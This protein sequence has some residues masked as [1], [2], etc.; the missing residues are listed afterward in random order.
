MAAR[1]TSA[2]VK[3]IVTTAIADVSNFIEPA[4]LIVD[5]DLADKGMSSDRLTQIELYLAAHFVTISEERGGLVSTKV[6]ESEDRFRRFDGAGLMSTRYGVM[7]A[8]L[9]TSGTLATMGGRKA[10]LEAI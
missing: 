1:V 5:E 8:S 6:G 4:T 9:D 2:E 10:S 7:A 3:A